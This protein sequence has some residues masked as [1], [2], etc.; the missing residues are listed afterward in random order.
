MSCQ[1][2]RAP[3]D[4]ERR[5]EH[6]VIGWCSQPGSAQWLH[7]SSELKYQHL[8]DWYIPEEILEWQMA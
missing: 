3:A 4:W 8:D 6:H 1:S 5:R 7:I 2:E